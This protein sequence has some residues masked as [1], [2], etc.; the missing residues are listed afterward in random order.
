MSLKFL[1]FYNLIEFLLTI[2]NILYL[3]CNAE[4]NLYN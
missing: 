3:C 1:E 2:M 4:I